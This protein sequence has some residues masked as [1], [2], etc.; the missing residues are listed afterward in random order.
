MGYINKPPVQNENG[1]RRETMEE[2]YYDY[3][4]NFAEMLDD[5]DMEF[6]DD[7][8]DAYDPE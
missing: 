4:E 3:D 5:M 8:W 2:L 6:D 7:F 1:E